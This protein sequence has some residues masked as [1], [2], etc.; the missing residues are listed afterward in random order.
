[1]L[2]RL[3]QAGVGTL[4]MVTLAPELTGALDAVDRLVAA[5]VV[6]VGHTDADAQTKRQQPSPASMGAR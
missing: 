5:G 1:V 3:L 4:A 6:A 2:D